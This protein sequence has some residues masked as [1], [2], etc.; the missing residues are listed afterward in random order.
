MVST[1]LILEGFDVSTLKVVTNPVAIMTTLDSLG[2]GSEKFRIGTLFGSQRERTLTVSDCVVNA[3]SVSD[4]GFTVSM[5]T[6]HYEEMIYLKKKTNP[7]DVVVGWT[8]TTANPR[9]LLSINDWAVENRKISRWSAKKCLV[10]PIFICVTPEKTSGKIG[11]QCLQR[12][13]LKDL[14]AFNTVFMRLEMPTLDPSTVSAILQSRMTAIRDRNCSGFCTDDFK[15]SCEI[16]HSL[17]EQASAYVAVARRA[18]GDAEV[19]RQLLMLL[20]ELHTDLTNI[21]DVIADC[22]VVSDVMG[23]VQPQ[24]PCRRNC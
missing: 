9:V 16:L 2:R 5:N 7:T 20:S 12:G 15:Q 10:E 6:A 14:A 19:A 11:L 8:V 24:A 23:L 22:D 17:L 18:G 4:D 21:P 3:F 1:N 13:P